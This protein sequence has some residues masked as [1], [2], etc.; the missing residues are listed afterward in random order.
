MLTSEAVTTAAGSD[1]CRYRGRLTRALHRMREQDEA[2]ASNTKAAQ[3]PR[4]RICLAA[5]GGG[6][7]R[8]LLDL[9]ACWSKYDFFFVSEDTALSRSLTPKY[10]VYFVR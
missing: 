6:H 7:I 10:P 1:I 8:Q 9:E 4:L 5:S 2:L 3:K